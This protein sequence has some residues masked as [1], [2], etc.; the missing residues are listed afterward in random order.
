[1]IMTD[2]SLLLI[3]SIESTIEMNINI[4]MYSFIIIYECKV[5]INNHPYQ[6]KAAI[7]LIYEQKKIV[8]FVFDATLSVTLCDSVF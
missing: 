4:N 2:F 8:F 3:K 7:D 6:L 1:M 5:C